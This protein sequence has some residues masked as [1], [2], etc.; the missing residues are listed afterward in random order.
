MHAPKVTNLNYITFLIAA[1][2]AVLTA[3]Y[4]GRSRHGKQYLIARFTIRHLIFGVQSSLPVK[5]STSRTT[6]G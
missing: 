3:G 6:S 2:K 5:I 1:P 4:H